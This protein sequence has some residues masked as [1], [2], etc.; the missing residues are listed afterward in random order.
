MC[1]ISLFHCLLVWLLSGLFVCWLFFGLLVGL[2]ATT[3][4]VLA[5]SL[6]CVCDVLC[7]RFMSLCFSLC[8]VCCLFVFAVV[9]CL[10]FF[11]VEGCVVCV[12]C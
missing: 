8:C 3:T 4:V 5:V 7:L 2:F 1:F 9:L 11:C 12:V 10:L 6:C